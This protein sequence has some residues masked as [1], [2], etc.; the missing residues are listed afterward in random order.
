LK[1][2]LL[3]DDDLDDRKLFGDAL[4]AIDPSIV[5]DFATDGAEVIG[6][7]TKGEVLDLDAI[8]LDVNMPQLNGWQC[9]N[10]LKKN[11]LFRNIPVIMYSTTSHQRERDIATDF[12]A[13]GFFSKPMSFDG[14]VK[15]LSV[16]V[17]KSAA[18]LN[19]IGAYLR[20]V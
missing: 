13:V 3:A 19:N 1:R 14:L 10:W 18:E 11:D 7:L 8:F 2:Y 6:K 15:V 4:K 16:L 9:L 20:T 12:G 5:C 17:S